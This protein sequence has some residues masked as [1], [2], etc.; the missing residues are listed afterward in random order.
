M[1]SLQEYRC[2]VCGVVSSNPIHWFVI[3][4]GEPQLTVLRWNLE[5]ANASGA[6]HLCGEADAQIYIGRWFDS[7]CSPPRPDFSAMRRQRDACR[8][9]LALVPHYR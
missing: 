7:V 4:C 6:R 2:E 8:R 3:L 1:S 9:T 5:S